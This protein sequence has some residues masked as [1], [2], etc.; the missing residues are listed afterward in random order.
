[1]V[2]TKMTKIETEILDKLLGR[3]SNMFGPLS[4]DIKQ[5]VVNVFKE[6]TPETWN[7]AY[8]IVLNGD[9]RY[10]FGLSLWEAW[11][12]TDSSAPKSAAASY[13]KP[14]AE[15]WPSLPTSE[16]LFRAIIYASDTL[17][18]AFCKNSS[19]QLKTLNRIINSEKKR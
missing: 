3:C 15:Q 8:S 11:V 19:E 18:L 12:R 14:L 10:G 4:A 2:A 7:D 9:V 1:M 13:D 17:E 5:R 16:A 6:Q